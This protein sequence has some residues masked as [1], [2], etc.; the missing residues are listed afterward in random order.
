MPFKLRPLIEFLYCLFVVALKGSTVAVVYGHKVFNDLF[1][2]NT[3]FT[4]FKFCVA[5]VFDCM[6]VPAKSYDGV[7][8]LD[9]G[10]VVIFPNFM[11]M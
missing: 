8:S 3:A 9:M 5:K 7:K 4:V 2:V 6:T 1:L 10:F 11:G